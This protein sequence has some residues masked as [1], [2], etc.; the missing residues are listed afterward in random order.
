MQSSTYNV[1]H[2]EQNPEFLNRPIELDIQLGVSGG[3]SEHT[4][5][6]HFKWRIIG[7]SNGVPAIH[8][9]AENN[10]LLRDLATFEE[11]TMKEFVIISQ[12]QTQ[13]ELAHRLQG[14]GEV[15]ITDTFELVSN[16]MIK[17]YYS[18]FMAILKK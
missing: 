8:F 10:Y 6:L 7:Y 16:Q 14:L 17:K 11:P 4:P 12:R 5:I 9:L 13:N 2:W 3:W 1:I 18:D 15:F